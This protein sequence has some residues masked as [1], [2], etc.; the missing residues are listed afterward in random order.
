MNLHQPVRLVAYVLV[1][2]TRAALPSLAPP[3]VI[4]ASV[5]R[6]DGRAQSATFVRGVVLPYLS[7]ASGYEHAC[8]TA[9][10]L[11]TASPLCPST[12]S[13]VSVGRPPRP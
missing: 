11:L 6:G 9:V 12:G 1:T 13:V 2:A 8:F 3:M 10:A 4:T 7:L 5:R